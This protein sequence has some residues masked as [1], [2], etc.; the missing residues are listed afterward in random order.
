[1][2]RLSILVNFPQKSMMALLST[3]IYH[4]N[5]HIAPKAMVEAF[6][7]E[8]KRVYMTHGGIIENK[9]PLI[10][11]ADK[12][13]DVD[14]NINACYQNACNQGIFGHFSPLSFTRWIPANR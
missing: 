1:M 12:S 2:G 6:L 3:D 10:L 7:G 8:F 5:T 11:Y 9:N 13:M 4:R 14:G